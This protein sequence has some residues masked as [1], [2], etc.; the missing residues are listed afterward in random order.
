MVA[1][2]PL[3]SE[4]TLV[5]RLEDFVVSS[6]GC[7]KSLYLSTPEA[8]YTIEVAKQQANIL[9]KY[10]QPGCY[11]KVAG[12]RKNKLHQG[13]TDY[14]AYKIELLPEQAT[15]CNTLIKTN[16]SKAQI[17]VCQGSSCCKK[18]GK[19]TYELLKAELQTQGMTDKV[20]IKTTGCL[21]QC[22]QAPNLVMPNRNRYSRVNP[23]QVSRLIAKYFQS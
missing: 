6:K 18:G 7:V 13:K 16:K 17:L 14:K 20:E 9:S 4:F 15:S 11:L 3:I 21:K 8:N 23:Q 22:K 19:G 10:L 2:Q 1:V 5:G 12:M